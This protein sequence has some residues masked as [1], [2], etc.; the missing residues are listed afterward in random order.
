M[1]YILFA[2]CFVGLLIYL[3]D[4]WPGGNAGADNTTV[5]GD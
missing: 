2:L 4:N 5:I 1:F 3:D